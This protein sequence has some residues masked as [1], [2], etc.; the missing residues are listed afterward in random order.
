[1]Q[2]IGILVED[3]IQ[4][5]LCRALPVKEAPQYRRF[6]KILGYVWV[7]VFMVWS[8][9]IWVYPSLYENRGE[10]KD[11]IV[12]YSVVGTVY[13]ALNESRT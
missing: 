12:P 13:E 10:E 11:L 5:I 6:S 2:A 9:P 1:M 3:A 7:F 4:T 8:T